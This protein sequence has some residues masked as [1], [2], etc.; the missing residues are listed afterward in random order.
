MNTA[1][2]RPVSVLVVIYAQTG[3]VLLLRRRQPAD[4]WQ[5]VT[6]SLKWDEEP[7]QAA[8]REL[9]EETGLQAGDALEACG[10]ENHFP[11]IPAWRV[12]YAPDVEFN[13]EHV[14]RLALES[15][16]R[17]RLNPAEHTE[18]GWFSVAQALT[19]ASSSTNRE[20]IRTL[21]MGML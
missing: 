2:K 6:G 16:C 19:R 4:Y 20:A 11:I 9:L 10:V 3:E 14:F 7:T 18:Y 1:F 8:A 13:T 5:S 15:P 17:I 12:R 21:P